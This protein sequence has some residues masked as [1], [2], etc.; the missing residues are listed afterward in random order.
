MR[1]IGGLYRGKKLISPKG[2]IVR[3]TSDMS[4]ETIFNILYSKLD[5]PW[6]ELCVLDVFSGSGAFGLEAISRGAK[7]VTMI[8]TNTENAIK[9]IS[10]FPNEKS[11]IKLLR[12]NATKMPKADKVYDVIF[13]DA[14]YNNGLTYPTISS[15]LAQGWLADDGIVIAEISR[16]EML[17]A[18]AGLEEIDKRSYGISSFVFMTKII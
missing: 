14:P 5:T 1:I 3:P 6:S 11:K 17:E 18:P 7:M 4:R 10:L 15:I 12:C 13:L 8:D 2:D 16:K 9:N